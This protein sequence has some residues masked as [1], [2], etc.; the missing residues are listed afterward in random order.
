[1][2]QAWTDNKQE[3]SPRIMGYIMQAHQP[4]GLGHIAPKHHESGSFNKMGG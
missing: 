4:W 3:D 2:V 1:M